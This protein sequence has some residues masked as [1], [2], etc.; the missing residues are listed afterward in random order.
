M[1]SIRLGLVH[2]F[3]TILG[4]TN[5]SISKTP[6]GGRVKG[7]SS[8]PDA[9]AVQTNLRVSHGRKLH[10]SDQGSFVQLVEING[11]EDST[12]TN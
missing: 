2:L 7:A 5:Q 12:K 8:R 9:I 6:M 1:P 4:S 3:P 11:Y 10:D